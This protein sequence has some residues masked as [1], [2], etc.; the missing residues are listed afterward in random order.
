M[1]K[2]YVKIRQQVSERLRGLCD[3]LSP[4]NRLVAVTV[5]VVLFALGNFYMIFRAI[6]DIGHEDVNQG[7][8]QI[9][10]IEVPEF[11]P[12]DSLSADKIQE[13]EEFFNQFNTEAYE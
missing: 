6:Y 9:T 10:P 8:M 12:T 1:K 7:V 2:M 11:V 3:R 5:L 13:M 4:K